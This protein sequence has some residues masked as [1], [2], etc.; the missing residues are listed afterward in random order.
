MSNHIEINAFV[1]D[2]I[3]LASLKSHLDSINKYLEDDKAYKH[4]DDV[5]LYKKLK[6][7]LEL[8]IDEYYS[9]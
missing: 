1:A 8:L 4:P 3:A 9:K 7:A 6:P 2:E 5:E